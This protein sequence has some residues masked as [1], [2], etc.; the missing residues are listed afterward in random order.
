MEYFTVY[1]NNFEEPLKKLENV[2]I[3]CKE[4]N[5]SLSPEKCFMMFNEVIVL[6]HHIL[7]DVTKVDTYKVEVISKIS[8]PTC[9]RDVRSFLNFTRYYRIFIEN[10]TKIASQIFK[11]LTK[12]CDFFFEF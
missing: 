7:G 8:I 10:S 9:R 4:D 3:R 5:L 6:A 1:G 12:Y 2:F 11:L